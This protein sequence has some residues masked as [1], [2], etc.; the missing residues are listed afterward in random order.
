MAGT[1]QQ[2]AGAA[3]PDNVF[4]Q[5]QWYVIGWSRDIGPEPY[6]RTVCGEP[7]LVYRKQNGEVT[8]MRDACPH[9]LL[10][11]SM[12]IKEGDNIRCRYHGLML[13]A[14]GRAV[15]MP[16]RSDRVNPALCARRY[17]VVERYSFVWVWIGDAA[18]A[19]PSLLPDYWM[20]EKE[21][22][23]FDGDTYFVRCNYQLLVDN[24]MDLTHETYVHATT[25][26]QQELM[27]TPINTRVEDGKVVVERW[28]PNVPTPPAYRQPHLSG[29]VDRWQ[30]C[31]FLPPSSV[32]IDVGVAPVEEGATLENHP[33]RSFVIDAMSPETETTTYYYWGAAR[34]T[35]IGNDERTQRTK[36]VQRQVFAEDL[37]VLEAQ[38][39]SL[40]RNPDLRMLNFNID[41]G[42]VRARM[43][44]RRML[45]TQ[46]DEAARGRNA[47]ETDA[48]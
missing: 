17:P 37:D 26:G 4:V 47:R 12:G 38:Q 6:A 15:E 44:I 40:A 20:C 1:G 32:V 31:Y 9:R 11:L 2:A 30:I 3:V 46:A 13:D 19:D 34:N 45:R 48:A 21:G 14:E 24:L 8:A 18:R 43:I 28:M 36:E 42:G 5:N 41:S 27:D 10:P 25:I 33:V 35:D 23:V 16:L 29:N 22:W 39:R 7:I